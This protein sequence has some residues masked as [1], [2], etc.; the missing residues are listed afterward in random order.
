[1]AEDLGD[2]SGVEDESD[3]SHLGSA[4]A[5]QG[6]HLMDSPDPL[7][8]GSAQP[9]TLGSEGQD[10]RGTVGLLLRL[11]FLGSTP[12]TSDARVLAG[13][14]HRVQLGMGAVHQEPSEKVHRVEGGLGATAPTRRLAALE[15][16]ALGI[17]GH[18]LETERR[19]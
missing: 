16:R 3:D 5:G 1:V 8:P 6:I 13:V 15:N 19:A 9:A 17:Q 7:S 11:R 12:G 4:P 14:A 18:P 10:G 2:H